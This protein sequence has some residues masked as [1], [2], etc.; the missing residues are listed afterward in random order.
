MLLYNEYSASPGRLRQRVERPE[1]DDFA[2]SS[3]SVMTCEVE[4][5]T[6]FGQPE[7]LSVCFGTCTRWLGVRKTCGIGI[8]F[9]NYRPRLEETGWLSTDF[10]S[11]CL[12][13]R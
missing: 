9:S 11:V 4:L 7:F 12:E 6:G 13:T 8:F 2:H 10:I 3:A 1:H 5:Q